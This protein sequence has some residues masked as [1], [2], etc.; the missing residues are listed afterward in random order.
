MWRASVLAARAM[1]VEAESEP[2]WITGGL[3]RS[4]C[5]LEVVVTREAAREMSG[6]NF[7]EMESVG[8]EWECYE[9]ADE[10]A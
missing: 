2:S 7:E 1:S 3:V 8:E 9:A 4:H 10:R 5:L 6:R